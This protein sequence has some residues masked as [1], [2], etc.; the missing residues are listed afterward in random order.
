MAQNNSVDHF[1]NSIDKSEMEDIT[2]E[3][4]FDVMR[5]KH[6]GPN[7]SM[8]IYATVSQLFEIHLKPKAVQALTERMKEPMDKV[9]VMVGT[10][11]FGCL[12]R[13]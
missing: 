9:G 5:L 2:N 11:E 12:S 8:P 4:L 7:S 1:I 3:E 10:H 13:S 6:T